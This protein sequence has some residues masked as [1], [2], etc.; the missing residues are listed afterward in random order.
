MG[1]DV[2]YAVNQIKTG[3]PMVDKMAIMEISGM[4]RS[5]KAI[6]QGKKAKSLNYR[7]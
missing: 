4:Q 3:I 6:G 2:R 7:L 1:N 5:L